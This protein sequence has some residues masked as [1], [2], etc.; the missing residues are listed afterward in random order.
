MAKSQNV[1]LREWILYKRKWKKEIFILCL[2]ENF[3]MLHMNSVAALG[4][5]DI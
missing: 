3:N 1:C 5:L 2:V 4:E